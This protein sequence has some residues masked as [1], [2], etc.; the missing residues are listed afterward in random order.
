MTLLA[1]A[2]Q[3]ASADSCYSRAVN[4]WFCP[5]YLRDYRPELVHATLE[6]LWITLVSVAVGLVVALGGAGSDDPGPQAIAPDPATAS[7]SAPASAAADPNADCPTATTGNVTTGRDAGN[8]TSGPG[9]IKAYDYAFYV[10]RSGADARAAGAAPV[11]RGDPGYGR[12]LDRDGDG[13]G[14]E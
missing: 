14:C 4:D 10:T 3:L 11:R 12:H 1:A 2:P 13:V 7:Q 9:A 5:A 6:H 8:F